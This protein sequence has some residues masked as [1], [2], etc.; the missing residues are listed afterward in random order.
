MLS[1]TVIALSILA[2]GTR[3]EIHQALLTWFSLLAQFFCD[4]CIHQNKMVEAFNRV[5]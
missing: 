3:V 5:W 4:S 1:L 2:L